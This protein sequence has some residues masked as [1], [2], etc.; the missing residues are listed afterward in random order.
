MNPVCVFGISFPGV[1]E[2]NF[3]FPKCM[4][5]WGGGTTPGQKVKFR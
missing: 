1:C 3:T 5:K 4:E 2:K